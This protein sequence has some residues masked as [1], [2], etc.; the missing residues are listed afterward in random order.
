MRTNHHHQGDAHTSGC[1]Y[2]PTLLSTLNLKMVQVRPSCHP[3]PTVTLMSSISEAINKAK[4]QRG[5]LCTARLPALI[6]LRQTSGPKRIPAGHMHNMPAPS[7]S[8]VGCVA[9]QKFCTSNIKRPSVAT[10]GGS[11]TQ[12]VG[13]NYPGI[14][15]VQVIIHAWWSHHLHVE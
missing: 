14:A 3:W 15:A 10:G 6:A 2:L 11:Q 1:P 13:D 12:Q 8:A 7:Y 4:G 5:V 9:P